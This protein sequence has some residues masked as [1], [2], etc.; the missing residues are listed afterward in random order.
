MK[1]ERSL[2]YPRR[3]RN[4]CFVVLPI[5]ISAFMFFHAMYKFGPEENR[6]FYG[7]LTILTIL[8]LFGLGLKG[9]VECH[10]LAKPFQRMK[11]GLK[12]CKYPHKVLIFGL[13]QLKKSLILVQLLVL[14]A[15]IYK[16]NFSESPETQ[17]LFG[18]L[19]VRL[20]LVFSCFNIYNSGIL[21]LSDNIPSY[22]VKEDSGKNSQLAIQ[23]EPSTPVLTV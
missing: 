9:D 8:L 3:S 18:K 19:S 17:E 16:S 14:A 1:A 4:A 15:C 7:Y 13:T 6:G 23:I 21:S 22:K 11:D 20:F 5:V 2:E 10:E 12:Q